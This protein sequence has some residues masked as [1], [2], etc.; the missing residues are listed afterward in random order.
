M[1]LSLTAPAALAE[2][3]SVSEIHASGK[4]ALKER[5][6]DDAIALFRRGLETAEEETTAWNMILGLALAH[7]LRGD[8]VPAAQYYQA[9]LSRSEGHPDATAGKWADRRRSA[10]QDVAKLENDVLATHARV[11][12]TANPKSVSVRIAALPE[13]LSL[14]APITLYLPPG[15]HQLDLE[16]VDHAPLLL[17]VSVEKGQRVSIQ[18]TLTP[19]SAEPAPP[20]APAPPLV[21]VPSPTPAPSPPPPYQPQPTPPSFLALQIAGWSMVG[22]GAVGLAGGVGFTVAAAN[23]VSALDAIQ[24]GP[25]TEAALTEDAALR[26]DL[27]DRQG[28]GAA[29]FGAGG[30]LALAGSLVLLL[31]PDGPLAVEPTVGL[32]N[33]GVQGRF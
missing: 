30:A 17:F 18:R 20:P 24:D 12:V 9:F 16:K 15:Q 6:Y 1:T 4:A 8:Q 5:R 14:T 13:G 19:L 26:G 23:T 31:G 32:G 33:L 22:L 2:T 21:L 3:E 29:M 11:F 28:A 27:R 25:V 10:E 7:D